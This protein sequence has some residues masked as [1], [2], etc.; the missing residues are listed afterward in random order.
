MKTTR[1]EIQEMKQSL[2][3]TER[4]QC[5]LTYT[6]FRVLQRMLDDMDYLICQRGEVVFSDDKPLHINQTP[7]TV[8]FLAN[9]ILKNDGYHQAISK[10]SKALNERGYG[11]YIYHTS[12]TNIHFRHPTIQGKIISYNPSN[13]EVYS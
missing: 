6:E 3:L 4:H 2:E 7:K 11:K 8:E 1:E 9:A 12:A 10:A 13:G 5:T